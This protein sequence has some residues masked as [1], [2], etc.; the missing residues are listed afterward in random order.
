MVLPSDADASG[1]RFGEE[2]LENLRAVLESGTLNC[3][4]GTFVSRLER[5]F[6]GSYA[7]EGFSCTAVTSGTA[8]IHCALAAL[9]LE[10]GD[11]VVSTSVTDMGAIA[12]IIMCG[13]VPVFADIGAK[14]FNISAASIEAVLS[15]RTR[16]VVAT[17]LFG[18][19]CEMTAIRA[20][21]KERGLWLVE[22]AAQAPYATFRGERMGTMGDIGCF[23]LQQGKHF[24]CGEGGLVLT[25][26]P[27]LA[28]RV[29]LFHDKAW[30]YGD[31]HPD[32]YFLAPNYRMTELA[33][34]VA[35]AQLDRVEEVVRDRQHSAKDFLARIAD[36][37]GVHPQLVPDGAQSVFWKVTLRIEPDEAG[38]DVGKIG[39]HLKER[40]GIAC[41]PRY[42]Q[43]P[44]FECEVLR[45]KRT[46]GT[47]G[48]PIQNVAWPT[49][50]SLPGTYDALAHMLVLPWNENYLPQHVAFIADALR[51][52]M[53]SLRA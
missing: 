36:L 8:A 49:R 16:A 40:F 11:E 33:G 53:A 9:D 27:D 19:S 10:P 1:R 46:F 4:R 2:E 13:A 3:T 51:E 35:L 23:S 14:T 32:H 15:P 39:A 25:K 45:D 52:T 28:R 12:P 7:G 6:A 38:A 29:R 21:C 22:D 34:A 17:H 50:D 26:N 31:A 24:S 48:W 37:R 42:V 30:G 44:A 18:A 43:K 5:G 41:A 20:L 47:S